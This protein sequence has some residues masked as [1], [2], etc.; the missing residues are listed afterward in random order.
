MTN[1]GFI[2]ISRFAR[3]IREESME[4]ELLCFR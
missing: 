1:Q 4:G 3:A 2:R